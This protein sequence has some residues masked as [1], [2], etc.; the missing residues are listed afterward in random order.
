MRRQ[1]SL[2]IVAAGAMLV[3]SCGPKTI[4]LPEDPVGRAATCGAVAAASAR[5]ATDVDAPLSLEAIGG[6]LHYPMMAGSA[7]D[8]FSSDAATQVQKRMADIQD[9]VGEGKWQDL[10]PACR[11]AFPATAVTDV[12][13]PED[14]FEA[15][16]G[17]DE[18]SDFLRS[19][20]KQEEEYVNELGEYR[21]LSY[22]LDPT[23]GPGVRS[24][25]GPNV[26]DQQ[27]V[28]RKALAT[29]AKAG[30]PVLV[31]RKCLERFG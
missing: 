28:R 17:C 1:L 9:R 14:R 29:M 5:L 16:L 19:A 8:S 12:A 18:L 2:G 13:L 23:V 10:I 22:K 24:R 15:Q 21:Q 30:Q 20:L 3:A 27:E 26:A 25:A 4:E 11:A 7:G 31:M 6:V